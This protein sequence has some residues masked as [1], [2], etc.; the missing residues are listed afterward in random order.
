MD[1]QHLIVSERWSRP[2]LG[3]GA[4]GDPVAAASLQPFARLY[5]QPSASASRHYFPSYDEARADTSGNFF[6]L[7][8]NSNCFFNIAAYKARI[9]IPIECLLVEANDRARDANKKAYAFLVGLGLGVWKKCDEQ[10]LWLVE[11]VVDVLQSTIL[12]HLADVEFNWF[13]EAVRKCAPGT[14]TGAAGNHIAIHFTNRR[15]LYQFNSCA[16]RRARFQIILL[17]FI[18]HR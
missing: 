5:S 6:R 1:N 18:L 7:F 17:S 13:P 14:I 11:V 9:R 15:Y 2:E 12:P 8:S 4:E 16:F 10:S 3:F